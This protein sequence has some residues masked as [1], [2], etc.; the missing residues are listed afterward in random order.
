MSLSNRMIEIFKIYTDT[1][2]DIQKCYALECNRL[3]ELISNSKKYK[4]QIIT[5]YINGT[6]PTTEYKEIFNK[7][8]KNQLEHYNIQMKKAKTKELKIHNENKYRRLYV[9]FNFGTVDYYVPN[10]YSDNYSSSSSSSSNI[11]A[12]IRKEF[13]FYIDIVNH[14][15]GMLYGLE[16]DTYNLVKSIR[17]VSKYDIISNGCELIHKAC[18]TN[19]WKIL[20]HLLERAVQLKIT[21]SYTDQFKK[22]YDGYLI[23][24]IMEVYNR[25]FDRVLI[26][27]LE[28]LLMYIIKGP[29]IYAVYRHG[30]YETSIVPAYVFSHGSSKDMIKFREGLDLF[31]KYGI[32]LRPSDDSNAYGYII[33]VKTPIHHLLDEY[34]SKH[35]RRYVQKAAELYIRGAYKH[36]II[37]M[38]T[39]LSLYNTYGYSDGL[40]ILVSYGIN[41]DSKSDILNNQSP[42]DFSLDYYIKHKNIRNKYRV[43]A[44]Y[45]NGANPSPI[46]RCTMQEILIDDIGNLKFNNYIDWCKHS[47]D[48]TVF[49]IDCTKQDG[50]TYSVPICEE[51]NKSRVDTLRNMALSYFNTSSLP[52]YLKP[53]ATENTFT[54]YLFDT[55]TT[56]SDQ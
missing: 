29:D 2:D 3:K 33:P 43:V 18:L 30:V 19:N 1:M 45:K 5:L 47:N 22:D 34:T 20:Y 8:I 40:S 9:R 37:P 24:F 14:N 26:I 55:K 12:D 42:I 16:R 27:M 51:N 49:S 50:T 10:K 17:R 52:Y 39:Y 44:L 38:F 15:K 23:K 31:V 36:D 32:N 13:D 28:L 11:V 53:R 35:S 46:Y 41:I 21:P 56:P 6:E 54:T 48:H 4:R 7:F 25:Y